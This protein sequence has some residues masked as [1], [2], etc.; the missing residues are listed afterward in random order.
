M[1][2]RREISF[3]KITKQKMEAIGKEKSIT[4]K[5]VYRR[6]PEEEGKQGRSDGK[7]WN[8]VRGITPRQLLSCLF[9]LRRDG[10][11]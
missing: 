10:G 11:W 9:E 4:D 5:K 6:C 3:P 8:W 2:E 7:I 1:K